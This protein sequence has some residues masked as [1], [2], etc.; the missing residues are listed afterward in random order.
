MIPL[1]TLKDQISLPYNYGPIPS[2][3]G[4]YIA[5][6]QSTANWK[7]NT[8][9]SNIKVY[10]AGSG[11]IFQLTR[12]GKISGMKWLNDTDLLV[13]QPDTDKKNQVWIYRD[14]IGDPIQLTFDKEGV[15]SLE[16]LGNGFVYQTTD[17]DKFKS[18]KRKDHFGAFEHIEE[19]RPASK[20]VYVSIPEV[21]AYLEKKTRLTEDEMKKEKIPLLNLTDQIDHPLRIYNFHCNSDHQLITFS[22]SEKSDLIYAQY[23]RNYLLSLDTNN[24][25]DVWKAREEEKDEKQEDTETEEK[26]KVPIGD[27]TEVQ[28]PEGAVLLSS[29]P[30]AKHI[31]VAY[32]SRDQYYYTQGDLWMVDMDNALNGAL[33]LD[34]LTC[35]TGEIDQAIM[36]NS[37]TEKGIFVS[38]FVHTRAQIS[39]IEPDTMQVSPVNIPDEWHGCFFNT[40]LKGD[41]AVPVYHHSKLSNIVF[42]AEGFDVLLP[43]QHSKSHVESIQ[44]N[45]SDG[46]EIEGIMR[47]PAN[48]DPNKKYP[49]VLIVHGGPSWVSFENVENIGDYRYY[50]S[51]QFADQEIIT[52]YP[53]YR[54]SIGRGQAF[55]ELNVNNLGVGDLWD[56]ESCIDH[57]VSQGFVDPERVGCMGWS[58]GGYISAFATTHSEKFAATSVGAGISDWYSYWMTTDIRKFTHDYL[59]ATPIEDKA[60]YDKTAPMSAIHK[61]KTPTLI[62]I[63]ENDKRVPLVNA[64]ELYRALVER[65]VQTHLFVYA[66]MPHGINKPR[67]NLAVVS[68]NYTW[69][70]HHLKGEE[71]QLELEDIQD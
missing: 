66:G 25:I 12:G 64:T 19:E 6:M 3:A 61:A 37:W 8:H 47:K 57:L 15:Q 20:L 58:Q 55:L 70:M 69:F 51:L 2:P 26:A 21:E 39:L 28:L 60:I 29:S 42:V 62:Q 27:L 71:L 54:G 48:F 9:D 1:Q 49:L 13:I 38:Y 24:E 7:D 16:I 14:L 18:K 23:R 17:P 4:T 10:F 56:I 53:N 46:T 30:D 31:L 40:N 5:F 43:V 67:E 63:G 41:L 36:G 32:Q 22:G 44:W 50:P 33:S 45:S 65:N 35:L 11:R 52:V 59:S 34:H 68:Q